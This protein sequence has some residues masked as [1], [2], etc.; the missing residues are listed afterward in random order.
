MGRDDGGRDDKKGRRDYQGAG[1]RFQEYD[2]SGNSN[3]VLSM[4]NRASG[5]SDEPTGEAETLKGHLAGF[6]D[7]AAVDKP[8]DDLQTQA[9]VEEA[10]AAPVSAMPTAPSADAGRYQPSNDQS[11]AA[12]EVL[13]NFA[14]KRC[15]DVSSRELNSYRKG[16]KEVKSIPK[17]IKVSGFPHLTT[18]Q[19]RFEHQ[20]KRKQAHPHLV[21]LVGSINKTLGDIPLAHRLPLFP[22]QPIPTKDNDMSPPFLRYVLAVWSAWLDYEKIERLP[23]TDIEAGFKEIGRKTV[24]LREFPHQYVM[25]LTSLSQ[26]LS[27]LHTLESQV[28]GGTKRVVEAY[29]RL[30]FDDDVGVVASCLQGAPTSYALPVRPQSAMPSI[31]SHVVPPT[32]SPMPQFRYTQTSYADMES[33]PGQ[34]YSGQ[35]PM[36]SMA[37]MTVPQA[38]PTSQWPSLDSY[39]QPP[40]M[41]KTEQ[42][43]YGQAPMPMPQMGPIPI[44]PSTGAVHT[45][46]PS[47]RRRVADAYGSTH[48]HSHSRGHSRS[49]SQEEGM[50]R[51]HTHGSHKRTHRRSL[52]GERLRMS[53]S[54]SP[55]PAVPSYGDYGSLRARV[56]ASPDPAGLSSPPPS[57]SL[58]IPPPP[59]DSVGRPA[60]ISPY[61]PQYLP[62]PDAT[63]PT[64]TDPESW[65]VSHTWS[66]QDPLSA[67]LTS[68]PPSYP[69]AP[70]PPSIP[71][72]PVAQAPVYPPAYPQF[73]TLPDMPVF[74]SDD[75]GM[76]SAQGIM[77]MA[78]A[79]SAPSITLGGG[80]FPQYAQDTSDFGAFSQ[81]DFSQYSIPTINAPPSRQ[82]HNN[83]K[84]RASANAVPMPYRRFK[85]S[86]SPTPSIGRRA[87]AK[88]LSPLPVLPS[89]PSLP[90]ERSARHVRAPSLSDLDIDPIPGPIPPPSL[91]SIDVDPHP[92]DTGR[93]YAGYAG[94]GSAEADH[95]AVPWPETA[96]GESGVFDITSALTSLV[97]SPT[98]EEAG[99]KQKDMFK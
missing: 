9:M 76:S 23:H 14:A 60:P 72:F 32:P 33:L 42:P 31:S 48:P 17:T 69:A 37:G 43:Y 50:L 67:T 7:R 99:A 63:L 98:A 34:R 58:P 36:E 16:Y 93:E 8:K 44:P 13:L 40:S 53:H 81:T 10:Q 6:G 57:A 95:A 64:D 90:R 29:Q 24:S 83:Y 70:I 11:Q 96:G 25:E 68:M 19:I 94:V 89:L 62:E 21:K 38:V 22:D 54:P 82:M 3:L 51:L 35:K 30:M 78:E 26:R 65:S 87:L 59:S 2:Y 77:A 12:Y 86:A 80:A 92:S 75:A 84:G 4:T 55:T 1:I 27:L 28:A 41:V 5:V 47:E 39:L 20:N 18:D 97:I 79:P 85:K 46:S 71:Q 74:P 52:S 56:S 91:G 73:P 66:A 61:I 45:I 88:E 49:N 15:G